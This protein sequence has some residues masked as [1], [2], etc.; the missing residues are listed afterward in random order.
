MIDVITHGGREAGLGTIHVSQ[1][2]VIQFIRALMSLPKRAD[3]ID[4][5][6]KMTRKGD[7]L[8]KRP[9]IVASRQHAVRDERWC[10]ERRG[11]PRGSELLEHTI[12][13][14]EEAQ[15]NTVHR[16]LSGAQKL[17]AVRLD[18]AGKRRLISGV[19]SEHNLPV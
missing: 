12:E 14:P 9:E 13:I 18:A 1:R 7:R 2:R 5:F 3:D 8:R 16:D 6:L 17:D 11:L 19:A 10:H 4:I 15:G